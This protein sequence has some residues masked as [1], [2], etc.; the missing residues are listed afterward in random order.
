M[1][2]AARALLGDEE[3]LQQDT[4]QACPAGHVITDS[5][6]HKGGS[7]TFCPD[8]QLATISECAN[9]HAPIPGARWG[10]LN[11][12]CD[13]VGKPPNGCAECNMR[14]PWAVAAV[15][16]SADFSFPVEKT[17]ERIFNRF[18]QVARPLSKTRKDKH[19]FLI[20]DEYD[21][22][23]LLE[24]LLRFFYD[25]VVRE[26]PTPIH[27]GQAARVD[28]Y[29]P[30]AR[31]AIEAKMTRETLKDKDVGSEL[32][33]DIARYR[34]KKDCERLFCFVYDPGRHIANEVGLARDLESHSTDQ[35]EVRV[36]VR[37]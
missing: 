33:L 25:D 21:V 27:A 30:D 14:F 10:P 4:M 34:Q 37:H 20:T 28:F 36:F 12:F 16:S 15:Q 23:V 32:L 1:K 8:H 29:L 31:A 18:T 22:Q 6:E 26:D 9:C 35:L 7:K 17:L 13:S 11:G 2:Y 19:P 5:L 24:S 3:R